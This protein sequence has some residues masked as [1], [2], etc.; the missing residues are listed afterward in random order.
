[1]GIISNTSR[2]VRL[3]LEEFVGAF[4]ASLDRNGYRLLSALLGLIQHRPIVAVATL[5]L[6][7]RIAALLLQGP[8]VSDWDGLGYARIAQNLHD[9]IGNVTLRDVPNVLH[10]PLYPILMAALLFVVRSPELAGIAISVL[11][12]T[13]LIVFVYRFTL[14]VS[15]AQ[16]AIVAAI[17]AALY[18]LLIQASID[19]LSEALFMA[20]AFAGL[21]S[22]V[23]ALQRPSIGQFT[24]AGFCFGCAYLTR[25]QGFAYVVIAVAAL[26][27]MALRRHVPALRILAAVAALIIPFILC[28]APYISYIA[29]ATGHPG[30]ESK[31]VSNYGVALAL[32]R[33][34][35]Y[36]AAA[37]A[38]GP[39]VEDVGVEMGG[40]Y[41]FSDAR[42][43]IPSLRDHL[44]LAH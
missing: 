4:A 27:V 31:S 39:H 37:D 40:S 1:L 29:R 7:L 36:V 43:P 20:L 2:G 12:G 17:L 10:A 14:G 6:M 9:G 42:V 18:P 33:G 41:P 35:T 34:S 13:L 38:I 21:D 30:L 25:E 8:A 28:A 23:R 11:S 19:P 16:V 15:G 44:R 3:D 32:S 24:I 26:L 22:L 5:G